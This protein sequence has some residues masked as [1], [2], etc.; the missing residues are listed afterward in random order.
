MQHLRP[1]T[2][3]A[4][5]KSPAGGNAGGDKNEDGM[6]HLGVGVRLLRFGRDLRLK[7]VRKLLTSASSVTV[8][9]GR[10]VQRGKRLRSSAV[11]PSYH[12]PRW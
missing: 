1:V 10:T 6:E 12:P 3:P 7:E 4:P 11:R 5:G 2:A 9:D 8:R